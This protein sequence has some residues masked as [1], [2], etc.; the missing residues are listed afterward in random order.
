MP[1]AQNS[2]KYELLPL[3]HKHS[4]T[5]NQTS[6]AT[7]QST[8]RSYT[9]DVILGSIN[10]KPQ[11]KLATMAVKSNQLVKTRAHP[12]S[13]AN[14]AINTR[15]WWRFRRMIDIHCAALWSKR[16]VGAVTRTVTFTRGFDNLRIKVVVALIT[17]KLVYWTGWHCWIWMELRPS[18]LNILFLFFFSKW[19]NFCSKT[20]NFNNHFLCV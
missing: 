12:A 7:H 5:I 9:F 15:S 20:I 19:S 4:S 13:E 3:F 10:N 6:F 17:L 16:G 2:R 18:C 8:L 1:T 11:I 14:P